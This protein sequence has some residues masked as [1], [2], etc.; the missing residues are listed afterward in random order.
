[1]KECEWAPPPARRR[2]E[3]GRV[4]RGG[5]WEASDIVFRALFHISLCARAHAN[6]PPPPRASP[7]STPTRMSSSPGPV[8]R[9]DVVGAAGL[10]EENR[11]LSRLEARLALELA[12]EARFPRLIHKR[13][14]YGGLPIG[15]HMTRGTARARGAGRRGRGGGGGGGEERANGR[16]REGE[17]ALTRSPVPRGAGPAGGRGGAH[18]PRRLGVPVPDT[19]LSMIA[20]AGAPCGAGRAHPAARCL[21]PNKKTRPWGGAPLH[22][23]APTRRP[24]PRRSRLS[25]TLSPDPDPAHRLLHAAPG[26]PALRRIPTGAW[27]RARAAAEGRTRPPNAF[28]FPGPPPPHLLLLSSSSQTPTLPTS[29]RSSP[30]SSGTASRTP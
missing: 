21:P 2:R 5:V 11:A 8:H 23:S 24:R 26:R 25:Q 14:V 17:R 4:G 18:R 13:P 28:S 1:M 12:V 22:T 29:S 20:G 15:A 16:G 10:L 9:N 19:I 7:D 27:R 3:Q 30:T 6:V